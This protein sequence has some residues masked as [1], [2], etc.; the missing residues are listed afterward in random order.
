MAQW[1]FW[2]LLKENDK[3]DWWLILSLTTINIMNNTNKMCVDIIK[4]EIQKGYKC[5]KENWS[6]IQMVQN[7]EL[8]HFIN[9]QKLFKWKDQS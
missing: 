8:N 2:G 1:P 3:L 9:R 7:T 6:G 5:R 4:W